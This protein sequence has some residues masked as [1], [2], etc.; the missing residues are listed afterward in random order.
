MEWVDA[1]S[2]Y[3]HATNL[4]RWIAV[5]YENMRLSIIKNKE[6]DTI[7]VFVHTAFLK[8]DRLDIQCKFT[9]HAF[10]FPSDELKAKLM[11]LG[12]V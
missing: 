4:P 9:E 8:E 2:F 6:T 11:L 5:P 1:L 12:L 7:T 10:V 3:E